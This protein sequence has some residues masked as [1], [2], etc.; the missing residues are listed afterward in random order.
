MGIRVRSGVSWETFVIDSR[1]T[2]SINLRPELL[3]PAGKGGHPEQAA[4][5]RSLPRI[6]R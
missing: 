6:E 4:E 5:S 3:Q 1:E 2:L